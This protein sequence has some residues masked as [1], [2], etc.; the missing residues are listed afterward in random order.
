MLDYKIAQDEV[1]LVTE[2]VANCMAE[3]EPNQ[4]MGRHVMNSLSTFIE[5]ELKRGMPLYI[6]MVAL[7]TS[8][9]ELAKDWKKDKFRRD[10][11]D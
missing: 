3:E 9:H 2:A 5:N 4:V 6:I 11:N 1:D 10:R 7:W 8:L